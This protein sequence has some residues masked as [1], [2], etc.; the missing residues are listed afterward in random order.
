VDHH[1]D[2]VGDGEVAMRTMCIR[3]VPDSH[4]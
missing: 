3:D 1:V 2:T 4:C